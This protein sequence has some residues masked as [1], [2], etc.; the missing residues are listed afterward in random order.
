MNVFDKITLRHLQR[1]RGRTIITILGIVLSVAMV[2]AVSGYFYSFYD[3]MYRETI[4]NHSIYHYVF[5][6]LLPETAEKLAADERFDPEYTKIV[7]AGGEY[8]GGWGTYYFNDKIQAPESDDLKD[9]LVRLKQKGISVG[10]LYEEL[11]YLYYDGVYPGVEFSQNQA[12]LILEGYALWDGHVDL[13][14][15]AVHIIIAILFVIIGGTSII[16]IANSFNISTSERTRQFGL[17][18]S[19]G[20]TNKQIRRSVYLE[21]MFLAVIAIPAGIIVGLGLLYGTLYLLVDILVSNK[22]MNPD[23]V[24]L[25]PVFN[26]GIIVMT[27]I[28][29]LAVVLLSA[30]KPAVRAALISPIDAIRQTKDIKIKKRE[31][32]TSPITQKLFGFEGTLAAKSLKRNKTG[33]RA[34][35][36]TLVVAIV[37]FTS[38]SSFV[39]MLTLAAD[40]AI[41]VSDYNV[42]LHTN[43]PYYKYFEEV[44]D[45]KVS[46]ESQI[47]MYNAMQDKID[48][49]LSARDDLTY[50]YYFQ[51]SGYTKLQKDIGKRTAEYEQWY[52]NRGQG[53]ST[54][55]IHSGHFGLI[56]MPDEDFK[57]LAPGASGEYPAVFVNTSGLV[58]LDGKFQSFKLF[59][60]EPGKILKVANCDAF[61]PYITPSQTVAYADLTI[62]GEID[63]I[64]DFFLKRSG[65]NWISHDFVVPM[66]VYKKLVENHFNESSYFTVT[67]KDAA[68]FIAEIE[69]YLN[70]QTYT[71]SDRNEVNELINEYFKERGVVT[72]FNLEE[73]ESAERAMRLVMMLFGYGFLGLLTLIAVTS[74]ISTIST[75]MSLRRRE[76]AMLYSIGMTEKGM[77]KMLNLESLLYGLKALVISLS[78]G[79]FGVYAFYKAFNIAAQ[80]PFSTPWLAIIISTAGVMLLTFGTMRYSKRKL[81]GINIVEA[82]RNETA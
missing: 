23:G 65:V 54:G 57:K 21:A 34:V 29:S 17:L 5:K 3:W 44:Y 51:S 22:V 10:G 63:Y 33:Y 37:L 36:T 14:Y 46:E 12:V 15:Y 48:K 66:S 70:S 75:S 59:D 45:V 64:P 62:A 1:N 26:I 77:N 20:A 52:E 71:L 28:I 73:I 67:A 18:K 78:I 16:T 60:I 47:K 11:Y 72:A 55:V 50:V 39:G 6:D 38:I 58:I 40:N 2:C 31:L 80:V 68:K 43:M 9:V 76:F 56:A 82:I 53:A 25:Y 69:E 79:T 8:I 27:A 13:T 74:V 42:E 24:M 7:D 35:T 30:W 41:F 61:S 81:R 19:V 32:K 49:Y 4:E